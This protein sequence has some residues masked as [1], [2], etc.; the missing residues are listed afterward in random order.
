M[1]PLLL[2]MQ[3]FG[4]YA[5]QETI[6]FRVLQEKRMFLISGKTGSGKTTIFDGISF[7]LYGKASGEDRNGPELRSHFAD[8]DCVTEVSLTFTL[9]QKTYFITRLP[10]QEKKKARGDG[11]TTIGA[12][13]ELF[14]IKDDGS[15]TL[16]AS[17]VRDVDE[18]MKEIIQMDYHQFKQIL[19]IPQGEFRK[20][21][22]SD[23]KDKEVIMQRLFQTE[24]FKR[25]EEKL[26]EKAQEWKSMIQASLT[27]REQWLR[28]IS[29]VFHDNLAEEMMNESLHYERVH[30]L[31]A[32][33]NKAMEE[34]LVE[35]KQEVEKKQQERDKLQTSLLKGEQI[36]RQFAQKQLLEKTKQ[37][38]E[39]Q[40]EFIKSQEVSIENARKAERLFKQE[41][42]C[43]RLKKDLNQV[44]GLKQVETKKREELTQRLKELEVKLEQLKEKEPL[45]K[46]LANEIMQL[47]SLK[48]E[49]ESLHTIQSSLADLDKRK[50][51]AITS[52]QN[53]EGK[54]QN[55]KE[56]LSGAQKKEKEL[57][58][59][60]LSAFELKDQL[61]V[62]EEAFKK[63]ENSQKLLD[64]IQVLHTSGQ[65][66]QEELAKLDAQY[67]QES[68]E[69]EKLEQEWQQQQARILAHTLEDGAPCPVC[70][71]NEHPHK[72]S[73]AEDEF[74]NL[75][76]LKN[77]KDHKK[78][79]EM[80][81]LAMKQEHANLANKRE[82]EEGMLKEIVQEI[83]TLISD[84][85]LETLSGHL[86]QTSREVQ[87]LKQIMSEHELVKKEL[88][89]VQ[90]LIATT[91]ELISQVDTSLRQAGEEENKLSQRFV[92]MQAQ[93]QYILKSLPIGIDSLEQFQQ[94]LYT[95]KQELQKL[96]Q[97][98]EEMQKSY[99][100]VKE[101]ISNTLGKLESLKQQ[102]VEIQKNLEVERDIFIS[103]MNTEG[104]DTYQV[105]EEAKMEEEQLK[106]TE[107]KVRSYWEELR[108]VTDRVADLDHILQDVEMPDLES[109]KTQFE[110]LEQKWKQA[111]DQV[112][113]LTYQLQR[114]QSIFEK[115]TNLSALI[116]DHEKQYKIIGE[117]ADISKGQNTYRLSFERF[118][119]AAFLD[120]ILKVANGRLK[121]MTSGRYVLMRKSDR[122][123][124]NVQSGLELLVYDQYTGQERHVKTLSGGESFKASLALALGLADVVQ[125]YAGGVSLETLFIDEGF[126][127]L[128]PE[129]LDQA[130]ETL[131][132]LQGNGRLVGII[133]HVPELKERIDARLDI[134]ATQT[135]STT[136]FNIETKVL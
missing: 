133:S 31:L 21:L 57:H 27:E 95:L 56:K 103:Q 104:F 91:Q 100:E 38:L 84:F 86:A 9:R 117:L 62:K 102:H 134:I 92:E 7:A 72:A 101:A 63:M 77:L 126:G 61:K 20:L 80:K 124:G 25:I 33:E 125:Q 12:K 8:D 11:F 68:D 113:T 18:K 123:K 36:V 93:L 109:L 22:T 98:K 39:G 108:S 73:V 116:Q 99:Q 89:T 58:Q 19:M 28:D 130:I 66:K 14:E 114:N 26:K 40:K 32:E 50:A 45:Q 47:E 132:E 59:K 6:D 16:L 23:S 122:S 2:T 65:L 79:T 97:E 37:E 52:K 42:V 46:K 53:L 136:R 128:D 85:S 82:Y 5:K 43:Q 81:L 119:L 44:E 78:K 83:E 106:G 41:Q 96:E 54:L 127:T 48:E 74:V 75:D 87:K 35:W 34:K 105:Y 131:F 118:V 115:V 3:A 60:Q 110:E 69:I 88:E 121:N 29:V 90:Q 70:G 129:S 15:Q 17:N 112:S 55:E 13:A 10:Q 1:R 94:R 120:D 49:M 76:E 24:I 64:S 67:K 71:S 4:P 111:Q 51:E 107:Q 135:G 30:E